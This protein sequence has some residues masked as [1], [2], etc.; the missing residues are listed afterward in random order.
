[1][2]NTERKRS[3]AIHEKTHKEMINILCEVHK[4]TQKC[5][6]NKLYFLAEF[7]MSTPEDRHF[8]AL[9]D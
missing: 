3:K 6:S 8:S 2:C 7:K 4:N 1:M 9:E 5:G